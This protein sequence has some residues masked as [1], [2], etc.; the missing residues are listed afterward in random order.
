MEGVVIMFDIG[1]QIIYGASG[2]CC[3]TDIRTE[4]FGDEDKLYYVL[5]PFNDKDAIIYVP[6]NNPKS[7]SKMKPVLTREEVLDMVHSMP[8]TEI[9]EEENSKLR[10]ELYNNIIKSGDRKELVKLIKTVHFQKGEREKAGKKIWAAD[11]NAMKKAEKL[12]YEE[13]SFVMNISYDEVLPFIKAEN[14]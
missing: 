10:K 7:V 9:Y 5:N 14:S 2:V 6:V 1:A 4:N 3:I 8:S 13:I 12:L 11:E